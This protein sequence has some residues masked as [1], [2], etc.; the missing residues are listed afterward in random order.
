MGPFDLCPM[1]NLTNN[2]LL[3][4]RIEQV[5]R[6]DMEL[7]RMDLFKIRSLL[8]NPGP[9]TQ[10]YKN[11]EMMAQLMNKSSFSWLKTFYNSQNFIPKDAINYWLINHQNKNIYYGIVL[12][13]INIEKLPN[14]FYNFIDPGEDKLLVDSALTN[15]LVTV[16]TN[17]FEQINNINNKSCE[18][19]N[20]SRVITKVSKDYHKSKCID[21]PEFI[22]TQLYFYQKVNI[23]WMLMREHQPL[24][25]DL[26]EDFVINWGPQI[27]INLTTRQIINKLKSK[28]NSSNGMNE[29]IGGCLCDDV[30]LGKTVQI[31]TLALA[32]PS[33][34]LIIIPPHLVNHWTDEFNKHVNNIFDA[35]LI[36]CNN[37]TDIYDLAQYNES[38]SRLIVI[39]TFKQLKEGL[40]SQLKFTRIVVDEFHEI[41]NEKDN[42]IDKLNADYKWVVTATPFVNSQMINHILNWVG[43]YPIKYNNITKYKN[44]INTF[45]EMFRKNTKKNVENELNLPQIKEIKYYLNFSQKERLFYDSITNSQDESKMKKNF[46]INPNLYFK[47]DTVDSFVSMDALD[48]SIKDYHQ[49]EYDTY[50]QKIIDLKLNLMETEIKSF[51][52]NNAISHG[53][54][55][56]SSLYESLKNNLTS[57]NI[58]KTWALLSESLPL[59]Y[60]TQARNNVFSMEKK[61]KELKS[62][63]TYFNSQLELINK[64]KQT[65]L[66]ET[67]QHECEETDCGI[68]L[69]NLDAQ[70]TILHCGH[71]FCYECIKL[72][73]QSTLTKCPM[74]KTGITNT[75]NYIIGAEKEAP[76]YGTKITQVIKICKE[77]KNKI[78]LFSHTKSLLNNL[79]TIFSN[80]KIKAKLYN[81]NEPNTFETDDVQVLILSSESNASGLNFQFVQ[82]V[83]LLE[84]LEGDYI[85]RKQ[86]ENQIIGRLH[87]IGQSK[88]IEFIRLIILDSIES[89]ID[90]INKIND[91]LFADINDEYNLPVTKTEIKEGIEIEV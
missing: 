39:G 35:K 25:V 41:I 33:T 14:H 28:I 37:K 81:Q 27:E 24:K 11:E 26:S 30:G 66:G 59:P 36:I 73:S 67:T 7:Y 50:H 29:F 48:D 5:P 18:N 13:E 79:S 9:N 17:H 20:I 63:M 46:C 62:K 43:K 16:M 57:E 45:S 34:T 1:D 6:N 71:M 72:I 83:I 8:L 32:K 49:K 51:A 91:A 3:I 22:K 65:S 55:V 75:T 15:Y 53:T 89:D 85:Y 56:F 4:E 12:M 80:Y 61:L 42:N 82:T 86:I 69:G 60:M 77:K 58:E 23:Y 76:N 44:H 19:E 87:R 2:V 78:I 54:I 70:F 52:D 88:P 40:F 10:L 84:P 38:T 90:K 47:A 21:Q 68:C 74:C 31:L 64:Q